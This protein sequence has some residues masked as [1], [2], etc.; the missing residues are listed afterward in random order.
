MATLQCDVCSGSLIM[1][2][3]GQTATCS[4]CGI[5]YSVERLREKIRSQTIQGGVTVNVM[6]AP[7]LAETL[8]ELQFLGKK[9]L[10]LCD[11]INAERVYDKILDKSPTDEEAFDIFNKLKVWKHMEV[12]NGVLK[13][14]QEDS[15]RLCFLMR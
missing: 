14:S 9:Y 15:A 1:N 3:G 6:T 12:E 11:W 4:V 8:E 5:S 2:T 13:N 10:K 7:P